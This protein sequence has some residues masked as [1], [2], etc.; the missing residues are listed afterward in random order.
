MLRGELLR[1]RIDV[2]VGVH[3]QHFFSV[4]DHDLHV[5]ALDLAPGGTARRGAIV[6]LLGLLGG[7]PRPNLQVLRLVVVIR[8]D[9]LLVERGHILL[10]SQRIELT[11]V[12]V[13]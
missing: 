11:L 3:L 2:R 9:A 6:H 10:V 12:H 1:E 8:R 13:V 4:A 7:E 5:E